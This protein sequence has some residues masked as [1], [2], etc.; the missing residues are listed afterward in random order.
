MARGQER[1]RRRGGIVLFALGDLYPGARE[2]VGGWVEWQL[3][4]FVASVILYQFIQGLQISELKRNSTSEEDFL[5][6]P[7]H[8][9]LLSNNTKWRKDNRSMD[10][11]ILGGSLWR[12]GVSG[13]PFFANWFDHWTL[14]EEENRRIL[15]NKNWR[16]SSAST[17]F[18]IKVYWF[19][20]RWEKE[21][22]ES[23]RVQFLLSVHILREWLL[24]RLIKGE[25]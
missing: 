16:S 6:S 8:S 15:N 5:E 1:E 11:F 22:E 12:G 7:S 24:E 23:D 18:I 13:G 17:T 20:Y 25:R 2:G 9:L 3:A 14:A 4:S 10:I 19:N 21:K